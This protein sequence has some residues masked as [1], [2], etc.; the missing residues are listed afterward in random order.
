LRISGLKSVGKEGLATF[1][2]L[3]KETRS[4]LRLQR[5]CAAALELYIFEADKLCDMLRCSIDQPETVTEHDALISQ[6]DSESR[7]HTEYLR[8][9]KLLLHA[10]TVHLSCTT[11][12]SYRMSRQV[13]AELA[14]SSMESCTGASGCTRSAGFRYGRRT[15]TLGVRLPGATHLVIL[16]DAHPRNDWLVR[17]VERRLREELAKLR[18][19]VNEDKS[20]MVD[21]KRKDGGF[22]FLGFEYRRILSYTGK[23]RPNVV[24]KLKKR[25]ALFGKLKEIFR[26]HVS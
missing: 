4:N 3:R 13:A 22:T 14:R 24:P 8:A 17:A 23:W 16:I 26:R 15:C 25:T 18:V 1:L 2:R 9:R 5:E 12:T 10:V 19:E 6:R 20:R 21:L 11:K 7:A